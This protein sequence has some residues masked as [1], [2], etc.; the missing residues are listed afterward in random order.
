MKITIGF[1][2]EEFERLLAI[3]DECYAGVER[4]T[5]DEFKHMLECTDVFLAK[6]AIDRDPNNWRILGFAIVRPS[7]G[8]GGKPYLW[9]IA[10][11]KGS[12]GQGIGGGLLWKIIE[13]YILMREKQISLHCNPDNPAQKLYFDQGFRVEGLAKNWYGTRHGLYMVR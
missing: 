11:A 9:S 13:K 5:V 10:V 2:P 3:N 8:Y 4:P 6:E 12:R 7:V 1:K